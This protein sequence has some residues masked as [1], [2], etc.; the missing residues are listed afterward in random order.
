ML[1]FLRQPAVFKSSNVLW[2]GEIMGMQAS[3]ARL[4]PYT[5]F[6]QNSWRVHVLLC[7]A[8]IQSYS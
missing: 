6:W 4:G 8:Q 2:K 3:L 1:I 7:D 5:L